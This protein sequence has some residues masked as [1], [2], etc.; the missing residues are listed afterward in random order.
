MQR[1]T[2]QPRELHGELVHTLG[3]LTLPGYTANLS[4]DSFDVKKKL[5][6]DSGPAM[7]R[8]ITEA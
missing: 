3:N 6:N 5:L 8:E 1:M 4:D 2:R 7:N